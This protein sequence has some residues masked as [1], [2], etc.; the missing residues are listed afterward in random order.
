MTPTSDENLTAARVRADAGRALAARLIADEPIAIATHVVLILVMGAVLWDEARPA[1]LFAWVGTVLIATLLR[2]LVLFRVRRPGLPPDAVPRVVR[3][4]VAALALTWGIGAA[5]LVPELS[6]GHVALMLLVLGGLVAGGSTTLVADLAS[7]R[8]LTFLML[9]PLPVSILLGDPGRPQWAMVFLIVLYGGLMVVLHRRGHA[10]LVEH[11]ETSARLAIEEEVARRERAQ[12]DALLASAP[13]AIVVIDGEGR[14][15]RV[16]PGFTELFGYAAGEVEGH[17]LNDLIVPVSERPK[18]RQFDRKALRGET[19][20]TEVER[21]RKDGSVVPVR[22]SAALVRGGAEGNV[23]VIYEDITDRRRADDALT[24]LASIVQTSEDAIIGRDLSGTIT[25]WNSGAER[26][27]GYSFAEMHGQP[28]ARLVPPDRAGEVDEM[29]D[30]IRRGERVQHFETVRVRKDGERVPVSLSVSLTRDAAG[31]V[32]GLSSIARDVSVQAAARLALQEARDAAERAAR[33]RSQFLAN[34]SHEIRT[35]MNAVLGLTELLLDTELSA[36]Q[37]RSLGLVRS[38]G[39]ALLTL[40]NDIL[41]FS[42][43][44][45]EHLDLEDIPYDLRHLVESTASLLAARARAKRVELIADVAASV[46]HMVRGDPTRMRQVLTNLVGNAIK[47]TE[48]GE[49][50]IIVASAG[51]RDGRTVVGFAVRDTGI[52]ISPEHLGGIF[53]EFT[54]ADASM[55]RRYGGTGLGL[56]I[57]RRLVIAMGGDLTVMSEVGRGSTFAFSIPFEVA[58]APPASLQPPVAL[59]GRR[60]LI[61]DD[62]DTNRRIL[63]EMLGAAGVEVGEAAGAEA[64]LT[65]LHRAR[66]EARPFDLAVIDAQMPDRDGFDFASAVQQDPNL[67]GLRLLMLTS[68]GQRGDAQRCRE[69]GIHGYLTKPLPR[70]D[71]FEAVA[72]V[73]QGEA[74]GERSQV[75]TRH[76]IAESRRHL[77]VLLAEDNPVNQ[78]VAA[79]MLRKRGHHVDVVGDGRAAVEAVRN[80][81]YDVVLMDVQMPELDGFAATQA[82]RALPGGD[83]VPIVALTAHALSGE[84]ERCL[85]AGMSGYLAKPFQPG[86]LFAIVETAGEDGGAPAVASPAPGT[87]APPVDVERFRRELREAGA[88]EAVDAI[89]DTFV[90]GAAE[91]LEALA[92]AGAAGVA[93]DLERAAHAYQSAAGA[94]GA[95]HLAALLRELESAARDGDVGRAR[96]G[97]DRVR[98]ESQRVLEYLRTS[99]GD[100]PP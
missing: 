53:E 28:I 94:V 61:V 19:V 77:R 60:I 36:D 41:D 72:A 73:L 88:E 83:R 34:M 7:F 55:T 38:S 78:E 69:V 96:E 93:R 17:E 39:E 46:P 51:E 80:S 59:A 75:V 27:F 63:R 10:A 87:A 56:T 37:R 18:A 74:L 6:V 85:A 66:S 82:I 16:N 1:Q 42:K 40:L 84:R 45:A 89:L 25:S 67:A 86:D 29:L 92:A 57:A 65:A 26:M 5:A 35:P 20:T 31:R 15:R 64:G 50:T 58:E 33:A 91:R 68:A 9:G 21:R 23:F 81:A 3:L 97:V 24:Q 13:V 79:T 30:L 49:V 99:R 70:S 22:A 71:L 12:L 48:Q 95:R 4:S 32:S 43:I 11:L 8:L 52:G 100:E 47:F 98:A 54:Q 76:S 2:R 44:D 14:V 62:S 90:A